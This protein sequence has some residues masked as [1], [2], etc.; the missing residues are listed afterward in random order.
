MSEPWLANLG[1]I[2][3]ASPAQRAA[4][5][6]AHPLRGFLQDKAVGEIRRSKMDGFGPPDPGAPYRMFLR[7]KSGPMFVNLHLPASIVYTGIRFSETAAND[8]RL[9]LI[10]FDTDQGRITSN[11]QELHKVLGNRMPISIIEEDVL[12]SE[13]QSL[14]NSYEV[15][16][17]PPPL[18]P[19]TSR[20]LGEVDP[21]PWGEAE[22]EISL[23]ALSD[24]PLIV[25]VDGLAA[26][27]AEAIDAALDR[28]LGDLPS[29]IAD[30]TP[31]VVRNMQAFCEAVYRDVDAPPVTGPG[32]D[33]PFEEMLALTDPALIWTYVS[34]NTMIVTRASRPPQAPAA[35]RIPDGPIYIALTGN[36]A[37]ETE[38]GVGIV[39][40]DGTEVS[41]V[42]TN[43]VQV[44][45]GL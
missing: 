33:E 41:A 24:D 45:S 34:L 30:A 31:H 12:R 3:L 35:Q 19:F 32:R 16:T 9:Y 4:W 20:H 22:C 18:P 17:P 8:P 37:W 23:P 26:E 39:W 44:T 25:V 1:D 15:I 36:C 6:S 40:R 42:G 27:D 28:L 11:N 14:T 10:H 5:L 43:D 29:R 38:H 2:Q 13:F 21:G 7:L